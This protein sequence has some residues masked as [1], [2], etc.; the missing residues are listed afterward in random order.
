MKI[1]LMRHGEIDASVDGKRCFT[2][3]R[4][5]PLTR[6][7]LKQARIWARAFSETH[8]DAVYCSDLMRC[9]QTAG[10]IA[11]SRGITPVVRPELKEIS[12]GEWEGSPVDCIK[13]NFP[14]LW[15]VRGAHPDGFRPPGGESF[16]DLTDRVF[17]CFEAICKQPGEIVL[18]VAHSGVNRA[19]LSRLLNTPLSITNP[20]P[21]AYGCLNI[22]GRDRNH[23][24]W[25][26]ASVNLPPGEWLPEG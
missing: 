19:I 14:D 22:I 18:I 26:I 24:R 15:K 5:L 17:P 20:I 9:R 1:Y 23:S 8:L 7:G 11:E 4:D 3:Q 25:T 21:Q 13:T 10:V 6:N 2:G 16:G 12:L